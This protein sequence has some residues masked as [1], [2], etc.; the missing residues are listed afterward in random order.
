MQYLNL[1]SMISDNI[2]N[3]F[4]V[5]LLHWDSLII[6]MNLSTYLIWITFNLF[7]PLII[8]QPTFPHK[9]RNPR[10][11]RLI[12]TPANVTPSRGNPCYGLFSHELVENPAM[13]YFCSEKVFI[14]QV[15]CIC[16][17]CSSACENQVLLAI[18]TSF[19]E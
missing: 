16:D 6:D 2:S 3:S 1:A 15:W 19:D 5:H 8:N 13:D 12:H 7:I 9:L 4:N 11:P 10:F 14:S 17:S 18:C